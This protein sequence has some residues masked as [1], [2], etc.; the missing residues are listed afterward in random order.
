MRIYRPIKIGRHFISILRC[1]VFSRI[2]SEKMYVT[3][4]TCQK[5]ELYGL[6]GT[7]L[8]VN[9]DFFLRCLLNFPYEKVWDVYNNLGNLFACFMLHLNPV[10]KLLNLTVVSI[11]GN[12]C[13]Q[14]RNVHV[15]FHLL[16]QIQI[17]RRIHLFIG[18]IYVVCFHLLR[19]IQFIR[20]HLFM[21]IILTIYY[22]GRNLYNT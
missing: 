11:V 3:D 20:I 6:D 18:V 15:C 8:I 7:Y 5:E 16:R 22:W 14:L 19:Q 4:N 21:G 17:I 10:N 2:L 9:N 13:K 12:L 1:K